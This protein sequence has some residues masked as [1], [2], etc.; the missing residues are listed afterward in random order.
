MAQAQYINGLADD[1]FV[2]KAVTPANA[3]SRAQMWGKS[4]QEFN[5]AGVMSAA[6]NGMFEWRT[7]PLKESCKTCL[8]MNGQ[9]HRFST[10]KKRGILP[11][12]KALAC[13][14]WLCG[15]TLERTT[16]MARGRF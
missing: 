16:E 6:A 14:G 7:N 13:G 8:R 3:E 5:N 9:V 2:K 4:L 10:Y 15:C 1:V 12:A 11:R